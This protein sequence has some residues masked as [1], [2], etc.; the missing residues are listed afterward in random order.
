MIPHMIFSMDADDQKARRRERS[1]VS[2]YSPDDVL[3][4][5]LTQPPVL[6]EAVVQ[7]GQKL[8]APDRRS[9]YKEM[10]GPLIR[11]HEWLYRDRDPHKE[12]LVI[13]LHPWECGLDNTPP[14]ISELYKHS[15]PAWITIL[16]RLHLTGIANLVRRD[17]RYVPPGQ[18]ESNTVVM[19]YWTALRRLKRKAY[20]SEAVLSRSLFAVQDLPFNCLLIRANQRL[21]E[22]A[23]FAGQDLPENLLVNMAK[24]EEAL[25]QLWDETSGQYFS[26]SFVSH[27]LIEE[28]TIGTL[29][30]LYSGAVSKNRA[31]HLVELLK[32]RRMF[33][34]SWPVPSVPLNSPSFDP[35][36]YWQGPTWVNMNWLII[37]GLERYGYKAEADI[38]K[39]RSLEM[40]NKSG[41]YE[42]FN[43]LNAQPAGAPNFSW[44]AALTIDLLKR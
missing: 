43:P 10:L 1:I 14:W 2:P 3:T 13:L 36:K 29:L 26:R 12:G 40:V 42:Y 41:M 19:A 22:I 35:I 18:R 6:A 27:K 37:D 33:S 25:E 23:K 20:N 21:K 38:L 16:D 17:T 24:S 8:K 28:P 31:A 30:P 9:W 39:R 34:L 15:M 32:R 4:S 5:G 11:H 7:V 44:T